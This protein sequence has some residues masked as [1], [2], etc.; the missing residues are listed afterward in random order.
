MEAMEVWNSNVDGA[1]DLPD[2]MTLNAEESEAFASGF[3]DIITYV[4]SF[5]LQVI[6]G[7]T[8][9]DDAAWEKYLDDLDAM[10]LKDCLAQYQSAYD[11]YLEKTA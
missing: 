6:T 8:V 7:Q 4:S 3:S 5:N 2:L 11:R 9:L 1:Y 10:G